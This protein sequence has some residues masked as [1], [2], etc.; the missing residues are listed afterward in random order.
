MRQSKVKPLLDEVYEIISTLRPSKGSALGTA[1]TYA[2]NQK[3]DLMRILDDPKLELTNNAAERA[4]RP[5]TVGRKNWLFCDSEKGAHAAAVL[6]S[7][8]NTA[9]MNGLKVYDY[10]NWVFERIRNCDFNKMEDLVP[11]S[12]KIPEYVRIGGEKSDKL[13]IL[14]SA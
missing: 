8:V 2:L 4:V 12:E 10:L 9:K 7:I 11:R 1:I 6:Y 14:E 13:S 3:K 5:V